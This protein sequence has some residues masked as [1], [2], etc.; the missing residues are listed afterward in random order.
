MSRQEMPGKK[1]L[2]SRSADSSESAAD[3]I[4][5]EKNE[6]ALAHRG[7]PCIRQQISGEPRLQGAPG[8]LR[9]PPHRPQ[10]HPAA[11]ARAL[12]S[13]T[14][15]PKWTEAHHRAVKTAPRKNI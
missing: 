10:A 11:A 9:P 6:R 1:I 3:R 13:S 5:L 15:R 14:L 7:A 8:A 12:A 2:I 4:G